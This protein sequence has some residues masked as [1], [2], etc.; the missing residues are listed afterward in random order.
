MEES[1]DFNEQ[2]QGKSAN[3]IVK[4]RLKRFTDSTMRC[5]K[6]T[7]TLK[8]RSTR[9]SDLKT[10][11]QLSII[12]I[13]NLSGAAQLNFDHRLKLRRKWILDHKLVYLEQSGGC[14]VVHLHDDIA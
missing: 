5:L 6:R 3:V 2:F 8:R 4:K 12:L 13:A 11:K 9:D 1:A 14:S 7:P 10:M